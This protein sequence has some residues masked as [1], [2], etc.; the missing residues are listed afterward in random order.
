MNR[1]EED[2]QPTALAVTCVLNVP[3]GE[4]G[5][6]GVVVVVGRVLLAS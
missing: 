2:A 6:G 5:G 3:R 4:W 1:A